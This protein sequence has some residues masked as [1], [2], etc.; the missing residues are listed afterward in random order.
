MRFKKAIENEVT[1]GIVGLG[2]DVAADGVQADGQG[3]LYHL[4]QGQCQRDAGHQLPFEMAPPWKN[5]P[6]NR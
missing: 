1:L 2:E 6:Q 3:L 4:R 5:C